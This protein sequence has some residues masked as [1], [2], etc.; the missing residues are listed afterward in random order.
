MDE[1]IENG[2]VRAFTVKAIV[3]GLIGILLIAGG[4]KFSPTLAKQSLLEHQLGIGIFFYFF[5]ICLLWNPFWQR[6][7]PRFAL[8]IK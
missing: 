6:F 3:A 5:L 4:S 1:K 2:K 8:N 7:Y